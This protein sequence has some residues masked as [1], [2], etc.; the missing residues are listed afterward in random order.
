M[1]VS[2][3]VVD[4]D[5]TVYRGDEPIAGA[6]DAIAR[7]RDRGLGVL[8]VT[9]N[10]TRSSEAYVERL[11]AFGVDATTEEVLPAGE[12]TAQF[13]ADRHAEDDV[14]CIGSSGLREQLHDHG[15]VPVTD[16]DD[17]DV[18]VTSHTYGF[19]YE[20]L[21]EG[22]WAL[23]AADRF[24]GT[25]PD[26]TYPDSDGRRYPGS[27][28]ITRAVAGVA[29]REPDRVLGKP[30]DVMVE[31]A[32]ERLHCRPEETLVV[33]DGLDTDIAFGAR[34]GMWTALVLSG[35]TSRADADG[36]SPEPDHVVESLSDVLD[37][38]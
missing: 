4:L 25:D 16:P 26:L 22:L 14:F 5:G 17:A 35:R 31:L 21:T 1:N 37:L 34:A 6:V 33:G 19:D 2:G 9:N 18:A 11:A 15:V 7:L 20:A 27:G 12:V 24:Y 36:A 23:D 32:C 10:P 38:L 28:A 8:F 13:L 30:S 29:Q 3:V